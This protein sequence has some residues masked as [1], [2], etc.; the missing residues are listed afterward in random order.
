MVFHSPYLNLTN[1]PVAIHTTHLSCASPLLVPRLVFVTQIRDIVFAQLLR[2]TSTPF[3]PC[4][5]IHINALPTEV[6]GKASG[7][8]GS[9]PGKWHET[10]H[11]PTYDA[12]VAVVVDVEHN[13]GGTEGIVV[14]DERRCVHV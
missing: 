10:A 9:D 3:T 6:H 14:E 5:I 4:S 13:I 7:Q 8:L 1:S 11:L 12:D 2:Y